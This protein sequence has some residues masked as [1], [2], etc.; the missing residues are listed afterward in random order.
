MNKVF[1]AGKDITFLS[2]LQS[3]LAVEGFEVDV[4]SRVDDP[5]K[6]VH[7]LKRKTPN[8]MILEINDPFTYFLGV[9]KRI[10]QEED[11]FHLPIFV[12]SILAAPEIQERVLTAGADYFFLKEESDPDSFIISFKR[13]IKNKS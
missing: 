10:K 7:D 9:I 11:L 12:F 13:I 4:E 3:R 6:A 5:V 1:L 8:Y 2:S